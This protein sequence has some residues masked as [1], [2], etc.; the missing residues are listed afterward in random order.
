[1]FSYTVGA[2]ATRLF[3]IKNKLDEFQ[4]T[5]RWQRTAEIHHR[6]F[7]GNVTSTGH[8][9]DQQQRVDARTETND[10]AYSACWERGGGRSEARVPTILDASEQ[11]LQNESR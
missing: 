5:N 11:T 9:C 1:M 3:E 6:V 2:Y 7:P 8:G 4:P 10:K